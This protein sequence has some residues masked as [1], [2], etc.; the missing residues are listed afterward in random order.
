MGKKNNHPIGP[1]LQQGLGSRPSHTRSRFETRGKKQMSV[2][3]TADTHDD[4][5]GY[6]RTYGSSS[7][8]SSSGP[9]RLATDAANAAC[10]T[11]AAAAA[12]AVVFPHTHARARPRERRAKSYPKPLTP[13]SHN[14][15][16][17]TIGRASCFAGSTSRPY[18]M[19]IGRSFIHTHT[20]TIYIYT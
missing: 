13:H 9:G 10:A 11:A 12:A 16:W 7:N 5:D 6:V 2:R 20:L 4:D 8:S 19:Y 3:R 17:P 15:F 18:N 1:K 14:R